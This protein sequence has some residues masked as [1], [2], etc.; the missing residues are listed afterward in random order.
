MWSV[1]KQFRRKRKVEQCDIM[2]L[3]QNSFEDGN[4]LDFVVDTY[5]RDGVGGDT[6]GYE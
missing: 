6:E 1:K 4:T 3:F 2:E 5:H